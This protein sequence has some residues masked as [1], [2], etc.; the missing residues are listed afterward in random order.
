M[1]KM[2]NSVFIVSDWSTNSGGDTHTTLKCFND[3]NYAKKYYI[4][5]MKDYNFL[6]LNKTLIYNCNSFDEE[7]KILE[8][9]DYNR[10]KKNIINVICNENV[11]GEI[12]KF[13]PMK[14]YQDGHWKRPNGIELLIPYYHKD[15]SDAVWSVSF[16]SSAVHHSF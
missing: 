6:N 13:Y 1:Q 10:D 4:E 9:S 7:L 8:S 15:N 16:D 2:N 11:H 3:Y 12:T 5:K 14:C